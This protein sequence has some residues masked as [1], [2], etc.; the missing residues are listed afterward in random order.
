MK[1]KLNVKE[2]EEDIFEEN[3]NYQNDGYEEIQQVHYENEEVESEKWGKNVKGIKK[4]KILR[5]KLR[6][7]IHLKALIVDD[8]IQ[9]AEYLNNI[10]NDKQNFFDYK[11]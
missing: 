3:E 1:V 2:G 6:K 11:P 5:N 7:L 8:V 4:E 9:I 10:Y